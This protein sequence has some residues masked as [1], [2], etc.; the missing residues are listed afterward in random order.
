M[1]AYETG[2]AA[3]GPG[4]G[5]IDVDGC[6]ACLRGVGD[7][8]WPAALGESPAV[9]C[10]DSDRT[11]IGSA[12]RAAREY[13]AVCCPRV[14]SGHVELVTSELCTNALRHATGWWR[15]RLHTHVGRLV[16]DVDDDCLTLPRARVPDLAHGSGGL[17]MMLVGELTEA[18][19]VLRHTRGKTVR[20][21]FAR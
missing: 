12:R 7:E 9:L 8:A 11:S 17:G 14:S 1:R 4:G 19:H 10:V 20:A 13:A 16:L 21:L 3:A 2:P 15:L 5:T 6:P 18:Y